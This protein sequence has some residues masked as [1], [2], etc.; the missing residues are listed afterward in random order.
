MKKF[1]MNKVFWMLVHAG[2]RSFKAL[3]QDFQQV[4]EVLIK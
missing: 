3:D 2:F 4:D 1:Q